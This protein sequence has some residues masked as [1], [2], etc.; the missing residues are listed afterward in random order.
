MLRKFAVFLLVF[1]FA[2][3]L[4]PHT[5]AMLDAGGPDTSRPGLRADYYTADYVGSDKLFSSYLTTTVEPNINY[6]DILPTLAA[7]CGRSE[8]VAVRWTGW[9]LCPGTGTKTVTVQTATDDT[10]RVWIGDTKVVDWWTGSWDSGS[11]AYGHNL[12]AVTLEGGQWYPFKMEYCQGYGGAFARIRWTTTGGSGNVTNAVIPA[13]NFCLDS[14]FPNPPAM[15]AIDTSDIQ[16][17]TIRLNV[18]DFRPSAKLV[19]YRDSD[20]YK[21]NPVDTVS[22]PA[23]SDNTLTYEL[24]A[25]F[26]AG[27]YYFVAVDGDVEVRGPSFSYI[28][29]NAVPRSEY[30]R[31]DYAREYAWESLNGAWDFFNNRNNVPD[32][33]FAKD[34]IPA[35]YKSTIMVPFP[36]QSPASGIYDTA[37]P[38]TAVNRYAWY[39]RVITPSSEKYGDG[40]RVY[41][42]FGAVDANCWVYVNGTEVGSHVGGY[43]PFE[44]DIT[45][46]VTLDAENS[47]AV[48]VIDAGNW[49][50]QNSF[51]ALIGKQG[52]NAPVGYTAT[53]GIWQSVILEGRHSKTQLGYVH[54][55][56]LVNN[57]A[58]VVDEDLNDLTHGV[59][60]KDGSAKFMLKILGGAG[61]TVDFVYDFESKIWDDARGAYVPTSPSSAVSGTRQIAVPA[62]EDVYLPDTFVVPVPDQQLWHPDAP[63]LYVG[64]V[65]LME[66]ASVLD[67]VSMYFGQRSIQN[68]YWETSPATGSGRYQYTLL[69]NKPIFMAGLLDQG[70]WEEGLY[71]APSEAALKFD[72]T[73]ML[74]NGFNMIRKHIKIEDPLQ[75]LWADR[76]GML[77][78]QD[79]PEGTQMNGSA[80]NPNPAGRALYE[81]SLDELIDRDYNS[82]SRVAYI[83]FN[84]TWGVSN[85]SANDAAWIASL[86][87]RVK[88]KDTS[89]RIIEDM[90]PCNRDHLQPTDLHTFHM[91]PGSWSGARNE[92]LGY[93]NGL[94][95]GS[96]NNMARWGAASAYTQDGDPFFNS[97]YGGVPSNG[98]DNDISWCFKYQTDIQRLNQKLQGYVYTEPFDVQYERNGFLKYDRSRKEMGYDE[99]AYGGDMSPVYL[100]AQEYVGVDGDPMVTLAPGDKYSAEFGMIRWSD[101]TK[102]RGPFTLKWRVDGTDRFGNKISTDLID[103]FRGEQTITY[104]PY[105]YETVPFSF[106]VP[107]MSRFRRFAGTVTVWIEDGNRQ[108]IAKNFVNFKVIA[109]TATEAA[110]KIM[111]NAFVLRRTAPVSDT[112]AGAAAGVKTGALTYEY[113][114]PD[115]FDADGLTSLRLVAELAAVQKLSTNGNSNHRPQTAENYETP[116]DVTVTVN[117]IPVS[118]GV[119]LPDG[120][121]DMR[122]IL[123]LN[124][125][126]PSS[127]ASGSANGGYGYL[128]NIDLDRGVVEQLKQQLKT[129]SKLTVVYEVGS[130]AAHK[131]G[132]R[133]YTESN[134]RYAVNP[135]VIL[136][137]PEL[138]YK[139]G[140]ASP[141]PLVP[142]AP[143]PNANYTVEALVT[144]PAAQID[145][146]YSVAVRDDF[147]TVTGNGVNRTV[148]AGAAVRKIR[149]TFFEEQVRVYTNDDPKPVIDVYGSAFADTGVAVSGALANVR[150]MPETF[151][152]LPA[153]FL[154][155]AYDNGKIKANFVN[156][157]HENTP[158][159]LIAAVY[160]GDG[161]LVGL[162]V[163]EPLEARTNQVLVKEFAIDIGAYPGCEFKTLAWRADSYLPLT[164]FASPVVKIERITSNSTSSPAGESVGNLIDNNTA[165]KLFTNDVPLTVEIEYSTP[166]TID[167]F[168]VGIA[169][170]TASYSGR[171]PRAFTIAGSNDGI[172]Y[173]A[174]FYTT[175]NAGLPATNFA[176][177]RF[178]LPAPVTYRYYRLQITSNV[179]GTGLQFSEFNLIG[180]FNR[181]DFS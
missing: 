163:G 113:T 37:H 181:D 88:G 111:D 144:G 76:L 17:G 30:P 134:G 104:A 169:N 43:T 83:L 16:S 20:T 48:K 1:S 99:M 7:R 119:F 85:S 14:G 51:V 122:A 112:N 150:I 179:S 132:V 108:T 130:G 153:Y 73:E 42:R 86:Y 65:K 47:V 94:Y 92:F 36:W 19:V 145:A 71:T 82:P 5:S 66:G 13:A 3:S 166:V 155:A 143:L 62:G 78:W 148:A 154:S 106:T 180:D 27:G 100:N 168:R 97:E 138:Y 72:I 147:V 167:S 39:R 128:V 91:Y 101:D 123:N 102:Y 126:S 121:N 55:D 159:C 136:N 46:Y 74:A 175:S 9:V 22:S 25:G 57:G 52:T 63:V 28:D 161:K 116:S 118:G 174:P 60:P 11:N 105:L 81:S 139:D 68:A 21:Q 31:P 133:A 103:G 67:E 164:E 41:I 4:L 23:I 124:S 24:P 120:P 56:P 12:T 107:V 140:A 109:P 165:T 58:A 93:L 173:D 170:D 32:G 142:D 137:P 34:G 98:G 141:G 151:S 96:T 131:N 89:G 172:N 176:L 2:F 50:N 54:V 45:D 77:F 70:F 69:N 125:G 114:V 10:C 178:S 40:K 87:D 157:G 53:S 162:E 115:D 26:K 80:S 79:M 29:M 8:Y 49:G 160:S 95:I 149:V 33:D 129:D 90:S 59:V 156:Q 64:T 146:G 38:G 75:Y 152:D 127:S 135:S 177:V 6:T 35:Q 158:V 117:G 61:K 110:E 18:A 15:T 84:E 44:F 171:N